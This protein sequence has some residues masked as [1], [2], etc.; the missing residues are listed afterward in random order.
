MAEIF[1]Y[2]GVGSDL[3]SARESSGKKIT[4]A[5]KALRIAGAHLEA[6]ESGRY[7]DLPGAVYVHGFV[8]SYAGFLELDPDEMVRRA[9]LELQPREISEELHFP[10]PSQ[11]AARPSS[12][13]LVFALVLAGVVLGVWYFG[14]T[15]EET[16]PQ[17]GELLSEPSELP[18]ETTVEPQAATAPVEAPPEARLDQAAPAA[19]SDAPAPEPV[20]EAPQIPPVEEL[21]AQ[22][23]AGPAPVTPDAGVSAAMAALQK[24]APPLIADDIGQPEINPQAPPVPEELQEAFSQTAVLPASPPLLAAENTPA[25]ETSASVAVPPSAPVVLSATSDTWLRISRADGSVVKSWVMRGGEHYVPDQAGLQVMVGNA[26]ALVVL[27]DG[28]TQPSLGPK[29]SVI[30]GLPLGTEEL[31]AYFRR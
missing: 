28:Q 22:T 5:T 14:S 1:D 4:D 24:S 19:A 29:G 26:G 8:R 9:Q 20:T 17:T 7:G 23:P 27:I 13:L 10:K 18:P 30:R 3:K 12:R 25:P 15:M 11:E 31:K 2:H 6:L 16:V 21:V